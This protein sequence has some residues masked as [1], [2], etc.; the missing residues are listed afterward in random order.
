[1]KVSLAP[2]PWDPPPAAVPAPPPPAKRLREPSP[3]SG[4][5]GKAPNPQGPRAVALRRQGKTYGQIAAALGITTP[6]ARNL[7]RRAQLRGE[8][9]LSPSSA[10]HLLPGVGST[11][12]LASARV[13]ASPGSFSHP[14]PAAVPPSAS[15]GATPRPLPHGGRG[16]R[17]DA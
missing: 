12:Q 6:S 9:P 13:A 1:M 2:A 8:L 10:A 3:S 15:E 5:G 17:G 11:G 4:K 16:G 14:L 7:C